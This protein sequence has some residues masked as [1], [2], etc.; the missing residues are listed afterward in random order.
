MSRYEALALAI[1]FALGSIPFGP[2]LVRL[3]GGPR[4]RDVGSGNIGAT[5]V[6]RASGMATGVTT[7]L[8]DVAKG[9]AGVETGLLVAARASE[10][11]APFAALLVLSPVLGHSYSPFVLFRGGKG[12]AAAIGVFIAVDPALAGVAL[13]AFVAVAGPSRYVSAGS[14]ALAFAAA[15]ACWWRPG[16]GPLAVGVVLVALLVLLRHRENIVR[17]SKGEENKFGARSGP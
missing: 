8:L 12:V 5:N 1:A 2:I 4:L 7:L 14:L 11:W 9:W 17:L 6:V 10:T 16:P 15:A 13:A 3:R